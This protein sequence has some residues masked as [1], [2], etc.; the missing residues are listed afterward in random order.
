MDKTIIKDTKCG[1][2]KNIKRKDDDDDDVDNASNCM[3][4]ENF[5]CDVG[6]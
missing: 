6:S 3:E 4:H 1:F 2:S 5:M